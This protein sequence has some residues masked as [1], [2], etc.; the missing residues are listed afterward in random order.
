MFCGVEY[1]ALLRLALLA[2]G[3]VLRNAVLVKVPATYF[4]LG[5]IIGWWSRGFL[6]KETHTIH[7]IGSYIM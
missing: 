6:Q 2:D 3:L 1:F 5:H 4:A 7:T